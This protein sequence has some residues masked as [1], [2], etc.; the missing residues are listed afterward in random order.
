MEE[1]PESEPESKY[2]ADLTRKYEFGYALAFHSQG[3]EIYYGFDDYLPP[4]Q[5]TWQKDSP[6]Q[7]DMYCQ[8]RRDWHLTEDIKIGLFADLGDQDLPLK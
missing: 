1:P 7:A 6:Y 5:N 3:E 2:L 8:N 4:M